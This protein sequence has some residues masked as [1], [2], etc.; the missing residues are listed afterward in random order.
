[1]SQPQTVT[2]DQQEILNR[3][4]EVEAPMATPP[5]D[6]PQ[7]PC[8][9]TAATNAAEQLAVS[10]DNVRLYLQAGE[11]ERQ[12]LATSLRN[13]AAAYGEVED[14]SAT[15]LDNDGNGE[16]EA[17]SA[18]GAGAGQTDS[19]EETPKVAAA[20]ESDFTD[21][22]TA[23]TKLESGDQGTSLVNFADGWN[24]FN[25]A[26]QRDIKRFRIFENWEGDAATACE[27]S[28]DQ[29]K[30]WILHMA[31]LSASL[32]KQANFM[33]QLQLWAR[34]GHPTLADIVELERLAKDPDYQE[35]AIKL[36]AEY[37]E[38]SEKVLSEYNT[39]ADL[40]PVNPP[41]PPAAI[42][43]DPPPPQKPPGLIPE[44][45]MPPGDGAPGLGSGM[46]PPMIPP[47]TGAGGGPEANT[48]G[49]VSAGH[50]AASD[51]SKGLGVKPM[52]LGGGGGGGLG[53]MPMGDAALAGGESVRPAAAGDV[54]GAGQGGG[55]AGRGMAGGGMGMPMGGAGQGQGGAKS[56]GAQQDEEALYTEDRE[57][58]E[59]VIGNRRRQG[60]DNK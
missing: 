30:E 24:N 10:A 55:A 3:A 31:K 56:K 58:T 28:M 26:L 49:L 17:Q 52:S 51:L 22:K 16:V 45:L 32:A 36:Y 43:I 39:K 54:A 11:R 60:Q 7:A 2:V 5:T 48:A 27:A 50:A 34:R 4:N 13:A 41:K 25:L 47:T 37:Q 8:G 1:M 33:A 15:A 46:A 35:Q 59:A 42:K 38:T 9:L 6:V 20:G 44:W 12:R 23:A 40:E 53:G 57:W 29:Q 14:E 21:L 19:L 18:G